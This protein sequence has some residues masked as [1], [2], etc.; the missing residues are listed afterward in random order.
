MMQT[1]PY[2]SSGSG[3]NG[4][5]SKSGY[6]PTEKALYPEDGSYSDSEPAHAELYLSVPIQ[7]MREQLFRGV[8]EAYIDGIMHPLL[9][10][11]SAEDYQPVCQFQHGI[12]FLW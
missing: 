8:A 7:W 3:V 10:F 4:H 9:T 11:H 6:Y 1:A 2:V 5:R 12:I